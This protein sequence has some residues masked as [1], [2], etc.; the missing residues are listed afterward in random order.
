MTNL[1]HDNIKRMMAE[2]ES[3]DREHME[4]NNAILAH[5]RAW[6]EL[7]IAL[8]A[9]LYEVL[10]VEPRSSLIAYALYYSPTSIEARTELVHNALNQ[11]I[12]E[13]PGLAP[14][15]PLWLLL[16]KKIG[17]ARTT[18]NAVAHG[19]PH[20]LSINGKNYARLTSPAFDVIRVGRPI[21]KG[22][23][24]GIGAHELSDAVKRAVYLMECVDEVNRAV[25]AF[26]DQPQTI[27]ENLL[28]LENRLKSAG[29][30]LSEEE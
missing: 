29:S 8:S 1:S 14:L 20:I 6:V 12:T 4:L 9:L 26:R 23:I 19:T 21:S 13:N 7:E 16:Y 28:S 15:A 25:A 3:L 10:N 17:R 30:L 22:Q 2:H 11:L 18:R 27:Q 5:Q 24:P